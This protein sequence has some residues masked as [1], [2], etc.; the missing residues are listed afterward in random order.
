M[1]LRM[2]AAL[3]STKDLNGYGEIIASFIPTPS[4]R[5]LPKARPNEGAN[6]VAHP[7]K[8]QAARNSPAAD[9]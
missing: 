1:I 9:R 8:R 6:Q 2:F 3:F 4:P 7:G 5:R